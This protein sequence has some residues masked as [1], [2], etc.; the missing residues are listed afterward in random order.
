MKR[1]LKKSLALFLAVLMVVLCAPAAFAAGGTDTGKALQLNYGTASNLKG[2]QQSNVYFGNYMQSSPD[3]KDPVKWRVLFNADGKLFL[4]ADQNLDVMPYNEEST[5]VTWETCTLRSW[6]NGY[7]TTANACGADYVGAGFIGSAFTAAEN[8]AIAVTDVKNPRN[9]RY[10]NVDSGAATADKVFL[11][12]IA[13][14]MDTT[15]GFT[16]NYF[17]TNTRVA[18]NT[19]YVA[20]GGTTGE[21]TSEVGE[22]GYWWLRSPGGSSYGAAH[23]ESS[24]RLMDEGITVDSGFAVRPALNVDLEKVLF[25]S[26]AKGGKVSVGGR[27]TKIDD[28]TG[29]DWKLTLLDES[30]N[31]AVT[32]TTA[33][34]APGS[35]VQLSFTGAKPGSNEY[36]SAILVDENGSPVYYDRLTKVIVSDAGTIVNLPEDLPLGNYTLKVFNEQYNGNY[37]TDYASAFC[38]VAVTVIEELDF[39]KILSIEILEGSVD[40]AD[41]R[42]AQKTELEKAISDGTEAINEATTPNDVEYALEIALSAVFAI[43]TD[44]ELTAEEL[45]AAKFYAKDAL[46]NYVNADDY[47]ADEQTALANA[48]RDGKAAID[49]AA[50]TDAVATALAAAKAAI[51]DIKT[52][53]ELTAEEEAAEAAANQAAADAVEAKIDAIGDVAYT[54]ESKAL[55]DDAQAAYDDLT[56]AQKALVENADVLTAAQEKYAALKAEAETPTEPD[57]GEV[58]P[59]CGKTEH[60]NRRNEIIHGVIYVVLRLISEVIIP[61]VQLIRSL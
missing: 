30:R 58:C 2:A 25:T 43:K 59:I 24:G 22:A 60:S 16:N 8:A 57:D 42:D 28:Y 40:P 32:E 38:D 23:V 36:I 1:T 56:D 61:T 55:I 15:Y 21:Y 37:K 44:A 54:D 39:Q 5:S 48:I 19:A 10:P 3:S 27:M 18:T 26:A 33:T 51:D 31:F 46:D 45:D 14:A 9:P 6:L 52:D 50:D 4:L 11:L 53:A 29:S 7:G 13:E 12:S 41:Y 35:G 34:A 47:R 49:A 17:T 20:S